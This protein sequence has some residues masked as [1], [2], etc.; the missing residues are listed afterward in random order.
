HEWKRLTSR[1]RMRAAEAVQIPA[2]DFTEALSASNLP[3]PVR[4]TLT[5]MHDLSGRD[6]HISISKATLANMLG[7][8]ERTIARHWRQAEAS[9]FLTKHDYPMEQKRTSDLWLWAGNAP[10]RDTRWD[11]YD[12]GPMQDSTGPAPF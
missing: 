10:M 5:V 9:G 2:P 12:T 8:N 1:A 11:K 6:R 3:G 7:V 4:F